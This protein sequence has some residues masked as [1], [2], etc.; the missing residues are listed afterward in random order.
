MITIEANGINKIELYI[1]ATTKQIKYK[2]T[3]A[4]LIKKSII[5]I[6]FSFYVFIE[7]E[8]YKPQEY[9]RQIRYQIFLW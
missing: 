3:N 4:Q 7:K 8:Y 9:Y 1:K 2:T 5:F 6:I